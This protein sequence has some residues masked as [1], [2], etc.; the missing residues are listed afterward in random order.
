MSQYHGYIT[1]AQKIFPLMFTRYWRS[2][3][4][5]MQMLLFLLMV[6]TFISLA[7]VVTFYMV[8]SITGVSLTQIVGLNGSSP[9]KVVDAAMVYQV[10]SSVFIFLAP[11]LL[12]AYLATPRPAGYLG[13]RKP[14]KP[15]QWV[16]VTVMMIS[17]IPL[18]LQI[19]AIMQHFN[20]GNKVQQMQQENDDIMNAFL[21]IQNGG[22]FAVALLV[23]AVLPAVCEE[24]FF[25][26]IL[27]RFAKKRSRN[28]IVPILFSATVFAFA[29][30][31]IYG[32]LSI[33]LAGVLLATIYYQTGSLYCSML[34]HFIYNGL[35]VTLLFFLKDNKAAQEVINGNSMPVMLIVTSAIVFAASFYLLLKNRTPLQPG[36]QN[37]Y[38]A[39]ELSEKAI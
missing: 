33:F 26:G 10:I 27:L 1:F 39:Q 32:L 29:H 21:N 19:E 12:F 9:R 24:L 2:Y 31:N 13:L 38:T 6:F 30:A 18:L 34:G 14:G 15:I 37:D 35:Q 11:S 28:M 7:Y 20:F 23:M 4:W 17:A 22:Q 8:P 5:M 36:W 16:L 3:P 25:R